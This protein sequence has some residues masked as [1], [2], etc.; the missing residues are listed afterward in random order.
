MTTATTPPVIRETDV[1][2]P[3]V[4]A[5]HPGAVQ[6]ADGSVT[7]PASHGPAYLY[8][9]DLSL[10]VNVALATRRPLLL[11]GSP[12]TGKTALAANVAH[13]L[14]RRL[15][16]RVIT[17]RTRA[18]D[19][20]WTYD[21]VRRLSDAQACA[22][23]G[24]PPLAPRAAYLEPQVLWRAF[25][26]EGARERRP[27][28]ADARHAP[29]VVLLDEIDKAEPDLP[30]DLLEV[31]DQASF[32]VEDADPPIAVAGERDAVLVVITTNGEREM[33]AAFLRRCVLFKLAP[34][35]LEWLVSIANHRFGADGDALHRRV[36][37]RVLD[38][39]READRLG[40]RQ[41]GTAEYLDALEA[42]RR[43]RIGPD[44]PQWQLLEQ[45]ALWKADEPRPAAAA[46]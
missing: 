5:R 7:V 24:S 15:L 10:A 19:L 18:R 4:P 21:A 30:N 39:R 45:A 33:P 46:S 22:Q 20:M 43:L 16:T 35:T 38:L 34:P 37:A 42:C 40:L 9:T 29:A 17:S 44:A 25:D 13:V 31:L 27:T 12:G 41:P 8:S 1:H 6:H 26:P 14:Q 11:A 3:F 36:A 23:P 2:D 32:T 28:A